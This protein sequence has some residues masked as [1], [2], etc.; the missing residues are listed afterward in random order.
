[1]MKLL[2]TEESYTAIDS[3]LK[4]RL[5]LFFAVLLVLIGLFIWALVARI[6]W[7]AMVF[8]CLAGCIVQIS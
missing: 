3:Q 7:A 6:Q 2:Y 4:R 8:A 5:A 1:M